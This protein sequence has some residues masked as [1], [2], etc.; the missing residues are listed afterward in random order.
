MG[1]YVRLGTIATGI[2]VGWACTGGGLS[3]VVRSTYV[4]AMAVSD[5][6]ARR[7]SAS[8]LA[9]SPGDVG[10]GPIMGGYVNL[11]GLLYDLRLN[12]ALCAS[13]AF[14]LCRRESCFL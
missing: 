11:R 10:Q 3:P 6:A 2:A 14:G 7:R 9:I 13:T 1:A 5:V 12:G 4:A 8:F